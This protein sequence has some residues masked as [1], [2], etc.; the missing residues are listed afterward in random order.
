MFSFLFF[1]FFFLAR[2]NCVCIAFLKLKRLL[3]SVAAAAVPAAD[4]VLRMPILCYRTHIYSIALCHIQHNFQYH[5]YITSKSR[6]S[7]E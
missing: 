5:I 1:S 4:D 3:W 7:D 6:T 2:E